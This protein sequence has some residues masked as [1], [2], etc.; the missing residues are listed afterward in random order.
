MNSQAPIFRP[1][2]PSAIIAEWPAKIDSKL[3][4]IIVNYKKS[5]AEYYHK[6]NVE[7]I[8][9]YCSITIFYVDGIENIYDE[10]LRLKGVDFSRN[11]AVERAR[12]RWRIPVCYDG[13]FGLDLAELAMKKEC[14][15]EEVIRLHVSAIYTVYFLGFMPGFMYLGGLNPLLHTP[16][17]DQPRLR[18]IKGAVGI[19]GAQTGIYPEASPG[20]W[21]LIGNSPV[22]LFDPT[23]N[24]PC[25]VTPGDEVQFVQIGREEHKAMV[26]AVFNPEFEWV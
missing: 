5:L 10:I 14:S 23:A 16:R 25:F 3:L 9:T 21:Q 2:G 1:F 11:T 26:E 19:A 13:E 6:V 18:V 20:G 17:K 22:S 15:I 8:N 7:I 4:K 12:K 24:P